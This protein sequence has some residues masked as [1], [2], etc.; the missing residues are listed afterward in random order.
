M[1]KLFT[2]DLRSPIQF[3]PVIWDGSLPFTLPTVNCDTSERECAAGW[4]AVQSIEQGFSIC[5]MWPTGRPIRPFRVE[6]NDYEI[7]ARGNK[8]RSA[9]LTVVE[10]CSDVMIQQALHR[11]SARFVDKQEEMTTEQ[12]CWFE[13]L[14]RP[15]RD[16]EAIEAGLREALKIRKLNWVIKQ[17]PNAR[18][19]WDRWNTWDRWNAW[20][21]RDTWDT[22]D[23]RNVRDAWDTWD[24]W[25]VRDAWNAWAA[26][27]AWAARDA[28]DGLTVYF[29]AQWTKQDPQLLT[30]GIRDAYYNGAEII[31]PTGSN[32]LGYTIRA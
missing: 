31:I 5:G 14:R 3:G 19:M 4:N 28:W 13:S 16:I 12:W 30:A 25:N 15:K 21:A 7:I 18:D 26:W 6:K 22:W 9:S 10:E 20:N 8:L 32:E 27:D 24:A 29:A 2:H 11:F 1:Y 23:A 17:Y